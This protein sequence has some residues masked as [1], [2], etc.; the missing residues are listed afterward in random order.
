RGRQPPGANPRARRGDLPGEL[1]DRSETAR[2]L[3]GRPA[4]RLDRRGRRVGTGLCLS[5]TTAAQA[6]ALRPRRAFQHDDPRP[7][8]DAGSWTTPA[9]MASCRYVGPSTTVV[10]L[11]SDCGRKWVQGTQGRACPGGLGA[12]QG[13]GWLRWTTGAFAGHSHG[14]SRAPGLVYPVERAGPRAVA[15]GG[16]RP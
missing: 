11:A 13:R 15:S 4:L 12:D 7:G 8:R 9:P 16:R 3:R 5:G 2:P 10:T 1:A 14:R 6:L